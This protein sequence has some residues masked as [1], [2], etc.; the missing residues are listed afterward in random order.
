[1]S[2]QKV[3]VISWSDNEREI[4]EY[5]IAGLFARG[6]ALIFDFLLGII[7]FFVLFF[8]LQGLIDDYPLLLL[9]ILYLPTLAL[10]TYRQ[11]K[12]GQSFGQALLKIGV[13]DHEGKSSRIALIRN[14]ITYLF[15]TIPWAWGLLILSIVFSREKRGIHDKIAKTWVIKVEK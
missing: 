3:K 15:F 6:V 9:P 2:I 5:E 10:K 13:A 1:M 7:G 4:R 12:S 11:A 14:L 8:L